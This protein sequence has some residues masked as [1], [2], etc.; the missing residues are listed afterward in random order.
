MHPK[1]RALAQYFRNGLLAGGD[2][3]LVTELDRLREQVD[4]FNPEAGAALSRR[5]GW[6]FRSG[7]TG[8]RYP[9]LDAL[10]AN[11]P[12][13]GGWQ[14]LPPHPDHLRGLLQAMEPEAIL[15]VLIQPLAIAEGREDGLLALGDPNAPGTRKGHHWLEGA[16]FRLF[17]R[18]GETAP[19]DTTA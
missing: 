7:D 15:A 5:L 16:I 17:R 2:E 10:L 14:S 18:M 3:Q 4:R 9:S 6:A 12:R 13:A 1:T 11:E 8:R 19:L